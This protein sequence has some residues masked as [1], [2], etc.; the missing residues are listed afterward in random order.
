MKYLCPAACILYRQAVVN[1]S[2]VNLAAVQCC[3]LA[4]LQFQTSPNRFQQ[5]IKVQNPL[6]AAH[7]NETDHT[8]FKDVIHNECSL[9]YGSHKD[10]VSK[11][12]AKRTEMAQK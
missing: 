2:R 1:V 3:G 5:C 6:K 11:C 10:S 9:Y 7:S 4:E 12:C 8:D